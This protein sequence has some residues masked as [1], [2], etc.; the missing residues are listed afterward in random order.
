MS[1]A[2]T[3]AWLA[4]L[5]TCASR[6]GCCDAAEAESDGEK[7]GGHRLMFKQTSARATLR[8]STNALASISIFASETTETML[9]H[10]SNKTFA[11]RRPYID[12]PRRQ[13]IMF[14]LFLGH[15]H[16]AQT[17]AFH[18]RTKGTL[19]PTSLV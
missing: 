12:S 10:S 18:F 9:E 6:R 13:Y 5:Q 2:V 7:S 4:G 16:E 8:L 1:T 11:G 14:G 19:F 15:K 3:P 17:I